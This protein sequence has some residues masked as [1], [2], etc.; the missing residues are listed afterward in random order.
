[1]LE[2]NG[3]IVLLVRRNVMN[4][5]TCNTPSKK[6]GKDRHGLQRFRCGTCKKTFLE[7]HKR[8][9]G[10]MRLPIE[11]AVAVIQ[12]LVEGCSIRT[13]ERITGV[14]K[15]TILSLLVLVGERCEKLMDH[16]KGLKVTE[17]SCDEIWGYVG[18]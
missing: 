18:M 6:F 11:K 4:C 12:H 15:R 9:L 14:E 3:N 8:P 5:P 17:V 13:T 2:Q 10:E 7:E 1:M 16:I